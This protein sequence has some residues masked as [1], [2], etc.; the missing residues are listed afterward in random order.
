M[1]RT[2]AASL[3]PRCRIPLHAAL[4][5]GVEIDVCPGCRGVWLD[6]GEVEK[7]INRLAVADPGGFPYSWETT[8][9]TDLFAGVR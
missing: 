4:R 5:Y 8:D 9:A 6:R 3:C 1:P 7:V 2:T